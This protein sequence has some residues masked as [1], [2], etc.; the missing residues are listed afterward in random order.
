ML[1]IGGKRH[2]HVAQA[3]R[4]SAVLCSVALAVC[5]QSSSIALGKLYTYRIQD[6]GYVGGLDALPYSQLFGYSSEIGNLNDAGQMVGRQVISGGGAVRAFRT[7]PNIA[8]SS[9]SILG[10]LGGSNSTGLFVNASSQ[11]FGYSDTAGNAAVHA[12]RTAPGGVIT[13]ESDLNTGYGS[14][15]AVT[16]GNDAGQAVG[17]VY[18]GDRSVY[19]AV[20]TAP[21]G[22]ITPDS[23]LGTLGGPRSNANGINSIG[24]VVGG[25]E[26]SPNIYHAFRT[27]ST[28]GIVPASD[29]GTLGGLL[30]AAGAISDSGVVVGWSQPAGTNSIQAPLHAIRTAPYGN[31]TTSTDLGTLGGTS[32]QGLAI[33]SLNQCVGVS[34]MPGDLLEHG[35]IADTDGPMRDINNFLPTNSGW[36]I[37]RA[38]GINRSGQ[39]AGYGTINGQVHAYIMTPQTG[40]ISLTDG[41]PPFDR[42]ANENVTITGGNGSYTSSVLNL[43]VKSG[44]GSV[45]VLGIPNPVTDRP[46]IVLLDLAGADYQF[47]ANLTA[48]DTTKPFTILSDASTGADLNQWN[49][50][51]QLYNVNWS[52]AVRYDTLPNPSTPNALDFSWNFAQV[53]GVTLNRIAVV[54]EPKSALS[55]LGMSVIALYRQKRC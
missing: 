53:S 52:A 45:D 40:T 10:T 14:S 32:A 26:I 17:T 37:N 25:A 55:F 19:H 23:D 39:V 21:N 35:F 31:V 12:F 41:G 9:G 33:N 15:T 20:R 50:I 47:L 3:L 49:S 30:S 8:I 38:N 5:F 54:P 22:K 28:G 7:A 1:T 51:K 4:S 11:V 48:P 24:E 34:Y 13:A 27:T 44:Q 36:V 2:L 46:I 43:A 18:F 42:P 16:A 29:L 6:L